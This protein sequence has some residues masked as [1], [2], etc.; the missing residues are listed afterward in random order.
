M[1]TEGAA[2]LSAEDELF[3]SA[4]FDAFSRSASLFQL[5][6]IEHATTAFHA[7]SIFEEMRSKRHFDCSVVPQALYMHVDD[8]IDYEL[9]HTARVGLLFRELT[10]PE[11]KL[12]PSD[13]GNLLSCFQNQ[14]VLHMGAQAAHIRDECVFNIMLLEHL[15]ELDM[16][17]AVHITDAGMSALA[18]AMCDGF[19]PKLKK[20]DIS[21]CTKLTPKCFTFTLYIEGLELVLSPAQKEQKKQALAAKFGAQASV[22]K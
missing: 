5:A 12:T 6:I 16:G 9:R 11:D 2:R 18:N 13:F 15:T 7:S 1:E 17:H 20:L 8:S 10:L 3:A 22:K 4:T 19:L 21:G 14:R